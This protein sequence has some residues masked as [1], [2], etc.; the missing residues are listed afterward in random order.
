[1]KGA[2]KQKLKRLLETAN[3]E[4]GKMEIPN[5]TALNKIAYA[6]A[7]TI[8]MEMGFK[9]GKRPKPPAPAWKIRIQRKID[10]LRRDLSQVEAWKTNSLKNGDVKARLETTYRITEKGL[11]LV[12]EELKQWVVAMGAKLQRYDKRHV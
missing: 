6:A 1:M 2:D 10:K 9:I 4:I 12:A 8:T 3:Q 7:I 5:L 11:L